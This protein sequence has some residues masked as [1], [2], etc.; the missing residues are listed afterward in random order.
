MRLSSLLRVF[1]SSSGEKLGKVDIP[2]GLASADA[3]EDGDDLIAPLRVTSDG[4]FIATSVGNQAAVFSYSKS[5]LET[6]ALLSS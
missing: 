2:S 5:S 4:R 6:M 1:D 3:S